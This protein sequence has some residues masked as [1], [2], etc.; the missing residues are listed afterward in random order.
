VA[1]PG[2]GDNGAPTLLYLI[3]R[4]DRVVRRAIGEV[5]EGHGLSVNEYST[6]SVLHRRGGLSNAQL[7][8]RALVSP[9][10]MHGVLLCLEEQGL[11]RRSAHPD[12]GRIRPTQLTAKGVRV[13]QACD[14]HVRDVEARMVDDL[15]PAERATL[16][17]GLICGVR[18]LHGGLD[19]D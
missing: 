19:W 11:V 18:A 10:S 12:H 3:G 17:K 9:Q 4:A 15:S 8:R 7:A 16:R 13:L 2:G 5:L 6:L 1:R 14:E